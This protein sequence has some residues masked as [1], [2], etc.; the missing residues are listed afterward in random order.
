VI[1]G[2]ETKDDA[3]YFISKE[4]YAMQGFYYYRPLSAD[5]LIDLLSIEQKKAVSE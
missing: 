2:I 1:E 5:G 3:D 4:I